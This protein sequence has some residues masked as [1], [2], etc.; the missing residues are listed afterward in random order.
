VPT[1]GAEAVKL[2]HTHPEL[3]ALA[4][5]GPQGL[6]ILTMDQVGTFSPESG[7]FIPFAPA[8]QEDRDNM[9]RL[10]SP[11]RSYHN[12]EIVVSE[13]NGVISVASG[14]VRREIAT[15]GVA[16][17]QPSVSHDLKRIVFIRSNGASR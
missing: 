7:S 2:A 6:V 15:E 3:V 16:S 10:R 13:R 9:A 12:D 14:G 4:G 11:G 8:T 17:L 5:S 1:G